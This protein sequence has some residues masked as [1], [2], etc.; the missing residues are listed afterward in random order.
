MR[1]GV[2]RTLLNRF[3]ELTQFTCAWRS[4]DFCILFELTASR[5]FRKLDQSVERD[6][7][8][9]VFTSVVA[10][11]TKTITEA[12]F[13]CIKIQ[14]LIRQ[15]SKPIQGVRIKRIKKNLVRKLPASHLESRGFVCQF[16]GK[17]LQNQE[18]KS[19][20]ALKRLILS[21]W[22]HSAVCRSWVFFACFAHIQRYPMPFPT[23][24]ADLHFASFARYLV[25][26]CSLKRV[27]FH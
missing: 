25:K 20:W 1:N 12:M 3:S 26:A 6:W 24:W 22:D 10:R 18:K 9:H 15:L 27:Q 19:D 4:F 16:R 13:A 17:I 5:S 7:C 14:Y 8:I 2:G 11:V 21:M 23:Q